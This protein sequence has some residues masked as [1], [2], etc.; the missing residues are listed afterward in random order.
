MYLQLDDGPPPRFPECEKLS[1]VSDELHAAEDFVTWLNEQGYWLGQF[2]CPHGR[3]QDDMV[4]CEESEYCRNGEQQTRLYGSTKPLLDLL[5]AYH[6][7][8]ARKL[9][10]ERR[11]MLQAHQH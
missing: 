1:A 9:D 7:I 11:V 10:D 2:K 5:Y 8:D 3:L 6:G 4:N